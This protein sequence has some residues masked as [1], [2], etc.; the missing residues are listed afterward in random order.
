MEQQP[1]NFHFQYLPGIYSYR[2][3]KI[4]TL[5]G[6]FFF[7]QIK[8]YPKIYIEFCDFEQN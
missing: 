3:Q 2:G 5:R 8:G 1:D 6:L 7:S 4:H